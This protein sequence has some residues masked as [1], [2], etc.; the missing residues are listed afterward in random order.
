MKKLLYYIVIPLFYLLSLFSLSLL[1]KLAI[2]IGPFILK[3]DK[4][5]MRVIHKNLTLCFP[6]LSENKK[7]ELRDRRFIKMFQVLFE[8]SHIWIKK[9]TVLRSYLQPTY[10]NSVFESEVESLNSVIVLIPHI[11]NWEMMNVY[12]SQYR[13][14]TAMYQPFKNPK[15]NDFILK[16]RQRRGSVLVSTNNRGISKVVNTLRNGGMTA[17]LPDQV[18]DNGTSGVFAPLFG[19]QAYTVTLAHKLALKTKAKVFIG[20]AYQC[21][22]GFSVNIRP[23]CDEFY[24][25]DAEVAATCLNKNIQNF[26]LEFPEQNQWEYNRYR[27]SPDQD[28]SSYKK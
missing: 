11:G 19:H 3:K 21:K 22:K 26:I 25:S 20:A 27:V 23:I 24:S 1:R 17:F 10:D 18:P 2:K 12:L 28:M 6:E 8:M 16:S 7:N 14:L 9:E 5:T 15:L 4:R 13:Q